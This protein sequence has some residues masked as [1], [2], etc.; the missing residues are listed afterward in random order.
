[1]RSNRLTDYEPGWLLFLVE[2]GLAS[3]DEAL[4]AQR[5]VAIAAVEAL[6]RRARRKRRKKRRD[7]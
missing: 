6:E 7:G 1:M 2:R 4:A 3:R 5:R